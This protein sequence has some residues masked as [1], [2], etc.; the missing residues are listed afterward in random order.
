MKSAG[1]GPMTPFQPLSESACVGGIHFCGG[2]K[3]L[4]KHSYWYHQST[5]MGPR[6]PRVMRTPAWKAP[7]T[8]PTGHARTSA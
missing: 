2:M 1:S 7:R 3:A 5:T 6:A 8:P 4:P